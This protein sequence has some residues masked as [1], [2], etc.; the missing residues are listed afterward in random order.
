MATNPGIG[1]GTVVRVGVGATP[2]WTT[3]DGVLDVTLPTSDADEIEVTAMDSPN[4]TKQFIAGLI[5]NGSVSV[6]MNFEDGSP[7]DVLLLGLQRSG[8]N[9]LLEMTPPDGDAYTFGGFVKT[10]ARNLPVND[11]MTAEATFR[12]SAEV[13]A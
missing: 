2:V 3:L 9:I 6:P 12:I 5:D 4:R 1:Y 10:Y 13:L 8:A 7:S 11:R